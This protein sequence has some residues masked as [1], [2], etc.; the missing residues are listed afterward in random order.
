VCQKHGIRCSY[1]CFEKECFGINSGFLCQLCLKDHKLEHSIDNLHTLSDIFSNRIGEDLDELATK[2]TKLVNHEIIQKLEEAVDRLEFT[3][4]ESLRSFKKDLV[5][6]WGVLCY[7][8][9]IKKIQTLYDEEKNINNMNES[10]IKQFLEDYDICSHMVMSTIQK[11]PNNEELES[12]MYQI[13]NGLDYFAN[14]FKKE[15]NSLISIIDCTAKLD[16]EKTMIPSII[17]NEQK[18]FLNMSCQ[19]DDDV[20]LRKL[21]QEEKEKVEQKYREDQEWL[22][23]H[24]AAQAPWLNNWK[25]D[26]Q[27]VGPTE[28]VGYNCDYCTQ[29]HRNNYRML[30]SRG[31]SMYYVCDP[32]YFF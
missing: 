23:K 17:P 14:L 16:K 9:G 12:D 22:R 3:I 24:R 18:Q 10:A 21:L 32:L 2:A 11:R 4:V 30:V 13:V 20:I 15:W 1:C 19:T 27:V 31:H 7:S 29:S 26:W 6:N 8:S 25:G 28:N 5:N